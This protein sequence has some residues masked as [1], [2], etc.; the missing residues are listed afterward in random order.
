[1]KMTWP[2]S[3]PLRLLLKAHTLN[4]FKVQITCFVYNLNS[5]EYCFRGVFKREGGLFKNYSFKGG[6]AKYSFYGIYYTALDTIETF[7]AI[8]LS[9]EHALTFTC[10]DLSIQEFA[11]EQPGICVR[12]SGPQYHTPLEVTFLFQ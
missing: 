5:F 3:D 6:G 4:D 9:L 10:T 12:T 8:R 7:E 2:F 1:M 11:F